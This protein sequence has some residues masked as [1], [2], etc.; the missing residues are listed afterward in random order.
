MLHDHDIETVEHVGWRRRARSRTRH[1][2]MHDLAGGAR[3]WRI[4]HRHHRNLITRPGQVRQKRRSVT[5]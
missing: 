1:Q 4:E 5:A 3:R 2:V